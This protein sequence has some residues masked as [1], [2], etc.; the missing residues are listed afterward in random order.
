MP[1][2]SLPNLLLS[3]LGALPVSELMLAHPELKAG[4]A[5]ESPPLEGEGRKERG[6]REE[7]RKG[8]RK[9]REG[10]KGGEEGGT[11]DVTDGPQRGA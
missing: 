11:E 7:G 9:E 2:P 5:A 3:Q 4:K 1:W 8:R 6:E 10:R